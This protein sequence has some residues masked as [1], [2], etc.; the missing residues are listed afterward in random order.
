VFLLQKLRKENKMFH[1]YEVGKMSAKAREAIEKGLFPDA[2]IGL[3]GLEKRTNLL[4]DDDE[5]M[6]SPIDHKTTL[7][8]GSNKVYNSLN[9]DMVIPKIK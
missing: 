7:V 2:K 5:E 4:L 3:L 6:I 1:L 9:G 8:G